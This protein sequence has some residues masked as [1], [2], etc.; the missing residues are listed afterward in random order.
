MMS[1]MPSLMH[2]SSMP[3]QT[4]LIGAKLLASFFRLIPHSI[5]IALAVLSTV[6]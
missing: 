2:V 4:T 5:R 1:N 3:K 6:I